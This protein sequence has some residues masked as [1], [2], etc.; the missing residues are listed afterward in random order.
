M[1]PPAPELLELL[2][3]A[4]RLRAMGLSWEAVGREVHSDPETCCRWPA[5]YPDLWRSLFQA[6]QEALRIEADAEARF[7]LREMLRQGD[8]K[9]KLSAAGKLVLPPPK[10]KPGAADAEFT[11]EVAAYLSELKELSDDDRD[12]LIHRFL[13][14]IGRFAVPA[15]AP[16]PPLAQ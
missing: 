5:E 6:A 10:P 11:S 4:A 8:E 16:S 3:Q 1:K 15:C 2:T 7:I 13:E 12:Q 9:T 14:D